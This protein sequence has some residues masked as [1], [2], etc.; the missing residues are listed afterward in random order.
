MKPRSI[1]TFTPA[2]F[3][4]KQHQWAVASFQRRF[5]SDEAAA[6]KETASTDT[7]A[8][9]TTETTETTATEAAE[10]AEAAVADTPDNFAQ[11]APEAPV[12]EN[13]TPAQQEAQAPP[14]DAEATVTPEALNTAAKDPAAAPE[15]RKRERPNHPPNKTLYVGNLFYEVKADQLKH[16][17]SRFGEVQD[18]KLVYDNRGISR[19]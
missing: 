1:T 13:L 17:F 2:A 18:V 14:T 5:A 11:T 3:R 9:E 15:A 7:A 19:G 8:T 16:I 12:E 10:A 4:S 6:S